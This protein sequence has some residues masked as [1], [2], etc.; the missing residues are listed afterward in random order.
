MKELS[1]HLLDILENSVRAQASCIRILVVEDTKKNLL[2]LTIQD[3]GKGMGEEELSRVRDPFYT[4][5][6]KKVGLGIPLLEQLTRLCL[7]NLEISSHPGEGTS[8]VARFQLDHIDLPPLGR[9]PDTLMAIFASHPD[10]EI[11]YE[12]VRDEC[13]WAFNTKKIMEE[14][15]VQNTEDLKTLLWG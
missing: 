9:L 14:L 15:D 7:G 12:H 2:L 3:N 1:L 4:G 10:I 11:E 6:K 5:Q 8:I 13:R